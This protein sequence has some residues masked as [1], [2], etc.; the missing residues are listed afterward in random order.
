MYC[1]EIE[2]VKD[3]TNGRYAIR[4]ASSAKIIMTTRKFVFFS[5]DFSLL[6]CD[7]FVVASWQP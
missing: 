1:I 6:Q 4:E 3:H 5:P 7:F 2:N